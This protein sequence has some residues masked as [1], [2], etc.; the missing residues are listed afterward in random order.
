MYEVFISIMSTEGDDLSYKTICDEEEL[1]L[2]LRTYDV[3][4][5]SYRKID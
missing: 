1:K 4:E 2:L 5:I 3:N